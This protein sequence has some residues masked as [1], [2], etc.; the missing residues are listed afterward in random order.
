MKRKC[1]LCDQ[2]KGKRSCIQFDKA[3]VCPKCCAQLRNPSCVTCSYYKTAEKYAEDKIRKSGG[4]S[5]II[6]LNEEVD[7]A[8][9]KALA[10]I[11]RKKLKGIWQNFCRSIRITIWS[12]MEWVLCS[13]L[14][15]KM[16]RRSLI[17]KKPVISHLLISNSLKSSAITPPKG[18]PQACQKSTDWPRRKF[19]VP[20]ECASLKRE[21]ANITDM[22]WNISGRLKSYMKRPAGIGCGWILLKECG[23]IIPANTALSLISKK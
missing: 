20:W 1:I 21:K 10:L 6:E 5:F 3:M 8:V 16:T 13:H 19:T 18:Q 7:K 14:S 4:K 12:S 23:G 17:L 2:N 15:A 22:L 9:D 11:E